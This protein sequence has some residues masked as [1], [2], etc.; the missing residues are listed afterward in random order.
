M[1]GIQSFE[2]PFG[3]G[4]TAG[5]PM[6]NGQYAPQALQGQ[7]AFTKPGQLSGLLELLQVTFWNHVPN[8]IC[9]C[10]DNLPSLTRSDKLP[11]TSCST[12]LV[13][14]SFGPSAHTMTAPSLYTCV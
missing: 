9:L 2:V 13:G 10:C 4:T 3:N 6:L 12:L 7:E 8:S 14:F 11:G 1:T 5:Q